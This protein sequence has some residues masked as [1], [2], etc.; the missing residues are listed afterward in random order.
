LSFAELE[1]FFDQIFGLPHW[2]R[3]ESRNSFTPLCD[4]A[5]IEIGTECQLVGDRLSTAILELLNGK[6]VS[7][8]RILDVTKTCYQT[9]SL[10]HESV[11]TGLHS[12]GNRLVELRSELVEILKKTTGQRRLAQVLGLI[13]TYEKIRFQE[14]ALRACNERYK[15]L[16]GC[17]TSTESIVKKFRLQMLAVQDSFVETKQDKRSARY[18]PTI[19]QMLVDS[20]DD[21]RGQLVAEVER[22]VLDAIGD[23]SDFLEILSD[24]INWQKT[25]PEIIRKAAQSVLSNAF[26]KISIDSVISKNNIQPAALK[27]WLNEQLTEATPFVTD[28]GGSATLLLGQPRLASKSVLPQIIADCFDVSLKEISGTTGDFVMCFEA[29]RILLANLAFSILKDA[30]EATEIAKRVASRDDIDWTSLDDLL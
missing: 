18:S 29:E 24:S 15:V 27:S 22:L 28:C 1:Q 14:F 5:E 7:F 3:D 10:E 13:R 6:S 26:K 25:L 21:N 8:N 16:K 4:A 30:P 11:M 23:E 19:Q 20:V 17:L 9:I 2:R 12:F